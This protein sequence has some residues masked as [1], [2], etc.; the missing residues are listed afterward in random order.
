MVSVNGS[1][2]VSGPLFEVGKAKRET[3]AAIVKIVQ[4]MLKIG[5]KETKAGLRPGRGVVTGDLQKG[6]RRRFN[7]NKLT[8]NVGPVRKQRG[9]ANWI[10]DGRWKGKKGGFKQTRFT[11]YHFVR[12]GRS[13]VNRQATSVGEKQTSILVRKLN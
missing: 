9:K 12:A 8:G 2:E 10:E 5:V 1:I 4:E 6:M 11:G 13:A 7:K 3:N